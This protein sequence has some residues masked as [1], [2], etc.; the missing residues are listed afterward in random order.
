MLAAAASWRGCVGMMTTPRHVNW[1]TVTVGRVIDDSISLRAVGAP[2][3]ATASATVEGSLIWPGN[4]VSRI[5]TGCG[6]ARPPSWR[7]AH[8]PLPAAR[9]ELRFGYWTRL[10]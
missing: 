10:C 1:H 8:Y 2:A 3:K 4:G 6:R 7:V 9:I 5:A